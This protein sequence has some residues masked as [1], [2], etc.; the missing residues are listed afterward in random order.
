M[1]I[2]PRGFIVLGFLSKAIFF[3]GYNVDNIFLLLQ[4]WRFS[5]IR[6]HDRSTNNTAVG[7]IDVKSID[8]II[9]ISIMGNFFDSA[10][11][12]LVI[13]ARAVLCT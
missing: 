2:L 8:L 3:R 11:Y 10:L 1:A 13:I 4:V 7:V 6:I 9:H 12:D 5:Q